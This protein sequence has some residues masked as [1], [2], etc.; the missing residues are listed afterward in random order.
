MNVVETDNLGKRYGSRWALRECSFTVGPSAIVGLVGPNGAGKSTLLNLLAGL[1]EPSDGRLHV[2][3]RD[4]VA[5]TG[6]GHPLYRQFTV[7]DLAHAGRALNRQWD[8]P[9]F[10]ARM[11]EL[12]IPWKR[13]VGRLSGGQQAQVSLALAL[14]KRPTLLLLDEPVAA[15]DPVARQDFLRTLSTIRAQQGL[16]IVLSTHVVAELGQICDH[17]IALSG[18]RVRLAGPIDGLLAEHHRS[19]LSDLVLTCLEQAR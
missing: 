11:T 12:D 15:L 18:G 5:F 4:R 14:A 8:E 7:A 17:L 10:R 16:T 1:I 2:A 19:D 3:G 13:R 9:G 6:Q